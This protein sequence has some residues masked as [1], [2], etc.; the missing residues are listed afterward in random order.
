[1]NKKIHTIALIAHDKKKKELIEWVK[2]NIDTLSSHAL[3]C[4]GTTGRMVEDII[5]GYNFPNKVI[6][7]KSGPL[8]G[9][10]QIGAMIAEGK[11][12]F[13]FFLADNLTAQPHDADVKAL[14]RLAQLYNIPMACNRSTA[15]FI[16]S[17]PLF[18]SSYIRI[19]PN[20]DEYNN[21]NI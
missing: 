5:S 2:Y 16:I 14:S 12:D 11:I 15:D 6:K 20:F 21:R 19:E 7:L 13:I 9:D 18:N 10:Q 8:G 3:I 1:M 4:T 17:S